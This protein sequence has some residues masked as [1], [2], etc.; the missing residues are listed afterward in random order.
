MEKQILKAISNQE[1]SICYKLEKLQSYFDFE[2]K[3]TEWFDMDVH[4][5]QESD[6][7]KP[8]IRDYVDSHRFFEGDKLSFWSIIGYRH[9]FLIC[10]TDYE[11]KLRDFMMEHCEMVEPDEDSGNSLDST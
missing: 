9:V 4:P 1:D 11:D 10:Q 6:G 2:Y 7:S 3:L 5:P 8:Q